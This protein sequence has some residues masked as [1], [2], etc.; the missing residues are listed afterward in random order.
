MEA[1]SKRIL[2]YA[3][4]HKCITKEQYEEYVYMMTMI[5]NIIV[6]DI[7]LLLIGI[8]MHMVWECIVFWLIYKA[9]HKYCGGFHFS[10][11]FRCYLST[12]IMCPIVLYIIKFMPISMVILALITS[13]ATLVLLV[14]VPVEAVNKPLDKDETIVFGKVARI[15]TAV[16]FIIFLL[17][18]LLNLY[19]IAKVMTLSIA[20]VT[21][22]VI[23]GK[24]HLEYLHKKSPKA[25][26]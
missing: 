21:V 19:I 13:T 4:L 20:S 7:S 23:A 16:A 8:A 2:D 17:T 22:F 14:L 1:V 24:L 26:V 9:L 12:I 5:L 18:A 6:T 3:V 25:S 11:S 10:T 15:L